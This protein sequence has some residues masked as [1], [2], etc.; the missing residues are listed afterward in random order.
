MEF[1]EERNYDL[2]A[3]TRLQIHGWTYGW[4]RSSRKGFLPFRRSKKRRER[5][6]NLA[7]KLK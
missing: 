2:V 4:A 5:R 3:A 7:S 6:L 1:L